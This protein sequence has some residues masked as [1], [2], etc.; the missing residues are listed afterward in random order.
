MLIAF[1]GAVSVTAWFQRSKTMR[2]PLPPRLAI[3]IGN[4]LPVVAT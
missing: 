3:S 2:P 4:A 1:A